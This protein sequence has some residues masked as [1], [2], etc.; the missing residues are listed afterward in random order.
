M[1]QEKK[2]SSIWTYNNNASAEAKDSFDKGSI[3]T[4]W[5]KKKKKVRKGTTTR[6]LPEVTAWNA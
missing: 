4:V 3:S 6:A 1:I 2:K 5:T